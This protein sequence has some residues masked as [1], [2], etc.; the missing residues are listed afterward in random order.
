LL[1]T[2]QLHELVRSAWIDEKSFEC[3]TDYDAVRHRL[4]A[5]QSK[6]NNKEFKPVTQTKKTA[7]PEGPATR[8]SKG[9]FDIARKVLL[10]GIGA[11]VLA[12]DEIEEFV[13]RLVERGEIAEKDGV[14]LV[15]EMLEQPKRRM[16]KTEAEIKKHIDKILDQSNVL[17]K[18]DFEDLKQKIAE[19]EK[20][21]DALSKS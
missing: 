10:A 18:N 11:T 21:I 13:T 1:K 5:F 4:S 2:D 7:K 16:E 15:Q 9:I 17:T 19:L 12:Q 3:Y 20:K 8:A 14:K 6:N